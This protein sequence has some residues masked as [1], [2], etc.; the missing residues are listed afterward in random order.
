MPPLRPPS[1]LPLPRPLSH[2]AHSQHASDTRGQRGSVAPDQGRGQGR[3]LWQCSS[4][5]STARPF[6]VCG[7]PLATRRPPALLRLC[8]L[9]PPGLTMHAGHC[10]LQCRSA[11]QQGAACVATAKTANT[12][13]VGAAG[14]PPSSRGCCCCWQ[15]VRGT[16]PPPSL[17]PWCCCCCCCTFTPGGFAPRPTN[18]AAA[19]CGATNRPPLNKQPCRCCTYA[20]PPRCAEWCGPCKA[21]SPIFEQLSGKPEFSS[22]TFCK[23]DVDQL[24]VRRVCVGVVGLVQS[25]SQPGGPQHVLQP[26]LPPA[27]LLNQPQPPLRVCACCAGRG[28]CVWRSRDAHLPS[29]LGWGEGRR[30]DWRQPS[31][32]G[33]AHQRVSGWLGVA[34]GGAWHARVL[35]GAGITD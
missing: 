12:R 8:V 34:A 5:E 20:H 4:G 21:I 24:Q 35:R 13:G 11:G 27:P 3:E 31:T 16:L 15:C 19:A 10:G 14:G 26:P 32:A 23:V 1:S 6:C 22:I 18:P 33:G 17:V 29:L 28:V 25:A 7:R 30:A 9:L 2:S